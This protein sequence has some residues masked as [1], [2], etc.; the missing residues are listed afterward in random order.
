M[1]RVAWYA[2]MMAV[3]GILG[4]GAGAGA[5]RAE[6]RSTA[7]GKLG[8]ADVFPE[9]QYYD[10]NGADRHYHRLDLYMP[11]GDKGVPVM[12]FL[13]GGSWKRGDKSYFGLNKNLALLCAEHHI[14]VAL[15][16]YRLS[17]AVKHPEHIKDVARAF[18]WLH[19]NVARYGGD[20][21]ELFVAG[22]SAGAHLAALLATD[23]SYLK[24]EGLSRT[25]I[26]GVITLSAVFRIPD[27]N[28]LF[29]H[30]FG[31]DPTVRRAASPTWHVSQWSDPAVVKKAP[32]F[33]VMYADNDFASCGGEPAEEF[34]RTLRAK[35]GRVTTL[36]IPHR[37]HLT[38][39]IKASGKD[40]PAGKVLIEFIRTRCQEVQSSRSAAEKKHGT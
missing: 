31:T 13:H 11:H 32:P 23:E 12:L 21:D 30:A 17:P 37:N 40:D 16:N 7:A 25:A 36:E 8:N 3:G 34:A 10:G 39:L 27:Q 6:N 26:R 38:I 9:I 18:A 19:R 24:A 28:A 15:A 22:H 29:D 20:P 5:L 1:R 4:L 2:V 33:L 14:G 35:G